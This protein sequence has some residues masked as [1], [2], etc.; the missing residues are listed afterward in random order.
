M[1]NRRRMRKRTVFKYHFTKPCPVC[2]YEIE[3]NPYALCFNCMWECNPVQDE[4][5]DYTGGANH[6]SLNQAREAYQKGKPVL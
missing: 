3:D 5:P 4:E 1:N 6:M 2:G